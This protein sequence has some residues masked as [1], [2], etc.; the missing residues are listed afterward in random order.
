M[1]LEETCAN[2]F[3]G[4]CKNCVKD[5]DNSHHPNNYDCKEYSA[6]KIRI[7]TIIESECNNEYGDKR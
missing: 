1:Q 7:N 5:I 6:L 4:R 2:R 3:L